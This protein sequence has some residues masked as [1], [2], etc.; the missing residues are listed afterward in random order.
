VDF[1]PLGYICQ[2]DICQCLIKTK[3]NAH[4]SSPKAT[5]SR[6]AAI[7][8]PVTQ[9]DSVASFTGIA[10]LGAAHMLSTWFLVRGVQASGAD[11]Q[12]EE[13]EHGQNAHNWHATS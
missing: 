4:S 6:S 12:T 9:P 13:A 5:R 10:G 7:I 1:A 3:P 11:L 2:A 8:Q